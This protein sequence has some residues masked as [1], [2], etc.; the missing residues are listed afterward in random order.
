M[1]RAPLAQKPMDWQIVSPH[2]FELSRR[3]TRRTHNK[4]QADHPRLHHYA[5]RYSFTM[6]T[7]PQGEL[8]APKD[9]DPTPRHHRPST[10]RTAR[11]THLP[12]THLVTAATPLAKV[13]RNWID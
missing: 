1:R 4:Q 10:H 9:T 2:E 12:T 3:I 13:A 8:F 11:P 7:G 5:G 6:A